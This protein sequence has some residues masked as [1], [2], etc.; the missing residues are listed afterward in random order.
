MPITL[1]D[2]GVIVAKDCDYAGPF[3][4]SLTFTH[5]EGDIVIGSNWPSRAELMG[6]TPAQL[7]ASTYAELAA[8]V[9]A[10][11]G[12]DWKQL[13]DCPWLTPDDADIRLCFD[14]AGC[15]VFEG[16]VLRQR[17]VRWLQEEDE[18]APFLDG[19]L[20]ELHEGLVGY[21]IRDGLPT[22]EVGRLG[23]VTGDF[24]GGPGGYAERVAYRGEPALLQAALRK[25]K[26]PFSLEEE[27]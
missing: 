11:E 23:L 3:S 16:P 8:E 4:V 13:N 17:L 7:T 18:E 24:R 19:L 27:Q 21:A 15:L 6:L 5:P 20:P 12:C 26:L 14:A 25:W 22:A 10:E 1:E 2:N 9:C